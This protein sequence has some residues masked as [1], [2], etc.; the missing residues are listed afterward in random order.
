MTFCN[1]TPNTPPF[2]SINNRIDYLYRK[3]YFSYGSITELDQHKLEEVN[4][5][6]F[7]GYVQN[8]QI[9]HNYKLINVPK[10]ISQIF[11]IIDIDAQIS[12]LLYKGVRKAEVSLR[13]YIVKHYCE[14]YPAS[15][16]FLEASNF[17]NTGSSYS[18][19]TFIKG[20][21]NDMFRC[22]EKCVVDTIKHN[23]S[24]LGMEVP[25]S[26]YKIDEKTMKKMLKVIPLWSVVDSFPLGHL[27]EFIIRCDTA[28]DPKEHLWRQ[29]AEEID[30][31]TD[32][33]HRGLD[34]LR[35]LR[36]LISHHARLWMRP[37]T[38]SMPKKGLFRREIAHADSRSMVI[39]FYN[40]AS[41]QGR[42][43]RRTFAD[44][45]KAILD[46]NPAYKYGISHVHSKK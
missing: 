17:L 5:H 33:F 9:L 39:A 7:L 3:G 19:A 40:I 41:F 11:N 21:A 28:Q 32:R 27:S 37:T 35:S 2:P 24:I 43:R 26:S 34:S 20:L 16:Y 14:K 25:K 45:L 36:N 30:F 46:Q 44:E 18:N 8:F 38:Y 42:D 15:D 29:I 23:C 1:F 12:A 6:H 31:K 10:N 13:Q 4:F 22:R